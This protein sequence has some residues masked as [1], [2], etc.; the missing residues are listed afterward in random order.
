[1]YYSLNFTC[2]EILHHFKLT[3]QSVLA[4]LV[5][6]KYS[7]VQLFLIY[8]INTVNFISLVEVFTVTLFISHFFFIETMGTSNSSLLFMIMRSLTFHYSHC[9]LPPGSMSGVTVLC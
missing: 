8:T 7:S 4:V 1:M 2:K 3:Y 6:I 5:H 9:F